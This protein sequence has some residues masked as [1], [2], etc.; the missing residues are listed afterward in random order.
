MSIRKKYMLVVISVIVF[1]IGVLLN[2]I[3]KST[4]NTKSSDF[5]DSNNTRSILVIDGTLREMSLEDLMKESNLVVFGTVSDKSESFEIQSVTGGSSIFTDYYVAPH[6]ILR[7]SIETT[8]QITVRVQGGE[9]DNIIAVSD[10]EADLKVGESYLLFLYK[11]NVGS[12]FNTKGD[13]FYVKGCRQGAY[14][15][16]DNSQLSKIKSENI[17]LISMLEKADTDLLLK[18]KDG[19]AIKLVEIAEAFDDFN[20]RNPVRDNLFYEEFL[21][22]L[23]LNLEGGFITNEEYIRC[24]NELEQYATIK[25][26]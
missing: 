17:S 9:L 21:K 23:K 26:E 22:N 2:V 10:T 3:C 12:G 24:L 7:G 14:E 4:D 1:F 18:S 16:K 19:K 13:Y 25:T 15:L 5:K 8:K 20:K 6:E 11:P